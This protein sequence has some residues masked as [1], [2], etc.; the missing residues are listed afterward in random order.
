MQSLFASPVEAPA[1][2]GVIYF[3]QWRFDRFIVS[4]TDIVM[5]G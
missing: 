1:Q 3:P 4:V 2:R 5:E